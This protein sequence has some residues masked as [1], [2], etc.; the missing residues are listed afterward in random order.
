MMNINVDPCEDFQ[1]FVCGKFLNDTETP[2]TGVI[3]VIW[4]TVK[5]TCKYLKMFCIYI[6]Q[7]VG[8]H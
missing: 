4:A 7:P 1:Q 3:S 8:F 5:D 2:E 6:C